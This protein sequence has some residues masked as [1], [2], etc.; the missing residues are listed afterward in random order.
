MLLKL[1]KPPAASK[2]GQL[3]RH[4]DHKLTETSVVRLAVGSDGRLERWGFGVFRP[5]SL[6]PRV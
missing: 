2:V 3:A 5:V 1:E 6:L 4:M